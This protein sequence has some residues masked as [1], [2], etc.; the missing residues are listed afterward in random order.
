MIRFL[1]L[2]FLL[3]ALQAL[4]G[5]GDTPLD[6]AYSAQVLVSD[7]PHHVV[8]GHVLIVTRGGATA[9]A[10]VLRHRDDGVHRLT[11]AEAWAGATRLPFRA[12]AGLGCT[13][14]HCRDRALGLVLLSAALFDRAA[15]AGLSFRLSGPSGTLDI[16]APPALFRQAAARAQGP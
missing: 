2:A 8:M 10:L 3:C 16:T 14:G 12:E 6:G 4:P 1:A 11:F 13:H 15:Q 9:R 7:H 5:R